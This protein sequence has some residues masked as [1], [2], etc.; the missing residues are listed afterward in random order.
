MMNGRRKSD[1]CVVPTKSANKLTP[2]ASA[3]QMEGRRLV[4]GNADACSGS[5][6]LRRTRP[7]SGTDPHTIRDVNASRHNL[8]QEPDAL[9]APVRIYGA[10]AQQCASLLRLLIVVRV[11][12]LGPLSPLPVSVARTAPVDARTTVTE[13]EVKLGTQM[14]VPSKTGNCG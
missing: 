9:E 5:R 10:G 2:G 8:R 6:T 14:F 11:S 7:A 3:E 1:S 4:K 13:F 12:L